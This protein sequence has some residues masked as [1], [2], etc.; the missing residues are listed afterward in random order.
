[1]ARYL[2]DDPTLSW[3]GVLKL[4]RRDGIGGGTRRAERLLPAAHKLAKEPNDRIVT[5]KHGAKR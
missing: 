2:R 5:K 3:S 1:M 4:M